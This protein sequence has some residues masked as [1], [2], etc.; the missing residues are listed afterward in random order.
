[1]V[2]IL[3]DLGNTRL[4]WAALNGQGLGE[5][6]GIALEG[7]DWPAALGHREPGERWILSSVNPPAAA[8]LRAALMASGVGAI[9]VLTSAA[10]VAPPNRLDEPS[11][12]G[13][14]RALSVR[15]ALG[16]HD[17]RGPGLVVSCGTA[18]CVERIDRDGVWHGGAI[19]VGLGLL[20]RALNQG[21][22]QLPTV[23][24]DRPPE[25]WGRSTAPAI[26]AGV[27]WGAVGTVRELILRQAEGL[28]PDAWLVWTGGDA[29]VLSGQIPWDEARVRVVP[30]LVL[31]GLADWCRCHDAGR[32]SP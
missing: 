4:K 22:A 25:P 19:A 5:V 17:G 32:A 18:L 24:P 9:E 30:E 10:E 27:F 13:T 3:A 20:S 6:A 12:T 8:R 7:E 2:T 14:D 15:G 21:T 26:A 28:G 23:L 31:L 1:M 11:R 29:P 16:L